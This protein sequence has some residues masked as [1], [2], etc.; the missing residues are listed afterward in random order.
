MCMGHVMCMLPHE[1]NHQDHQEHA[2]KS[3]LEILKIRYA[4]GEI[5]KEEYDEKKKDIA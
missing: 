1:M 5:S 3:A 4:K 2:S